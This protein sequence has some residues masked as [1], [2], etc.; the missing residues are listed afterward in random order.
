MSS[1]APPV[2]APS[3]I[4]PRALGVAV[5]VGASVLI[6]LVARLA[7]TDLTVGIEGREP[8][9]VGLGPVVAVSLGAALLAWGALVVLERLT[10]RGTA[11]WSA[12][13]VVLT[14]ASMLPLSAADA[15]A[16]A[17][18]ALG[19]MHLAVG[20]AVLAFLPRRSR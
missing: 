5:A 4:R 7:G 6:W 19:L 1:A 15:D 17:K 18:V 13:V 2:T 9:V 14:L 3:T 10:G 12:L 11:V 20:G 8:M 16:G